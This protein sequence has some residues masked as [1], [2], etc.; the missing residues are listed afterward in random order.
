MS[1]RRLPHLATL[2]MGSK[3]PRKPSRKT[4]TANQVRLIE[5][6]HHIKQLQ[7]VT[8]KDLMDR[9]EVSRATLRR[10]FDLLRDRLNMP[11]VYDR[12]T[13][14]YS[15]SDSPG[16][17]GGQFELPGLWLR[18][19]EAYALLTLFNVLQKI[20][21]GLLEMYISPLRGIIKRVLA[22]KEFDMMGL[23]MK[24]DVELGDFKNPRQNVFNRLSQALLGNNKIVLKFNDKAGLVDGEYWIEKFIL[25]PNGW[26]LA[27][28]GC[29]TR[30][31]IRCAAISVHEVSIVE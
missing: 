10:D 23:D 22:E 2:K 11:V 24:I 12:W 25:T 20:D 8:F 28:F 4:D 14:G 3:M 29:Q 30:R 5:L 15:I 7:P 18:T 26:D 19:D 27:L 13:G 1:L 17:F 21:P 9:L 31:I 6:V 16:R